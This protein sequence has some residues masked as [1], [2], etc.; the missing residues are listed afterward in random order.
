MIPTYYRTTASGEPLASAYLHHRASTRGIPLAGTFEL[1]ARCNFNCKMCYVHH[2]A[3]VDRELSTQSWIDLGKTAAQNGMLFLLL[4]GGEPLLREDFPEIYVA[5]KKLGLMISINTN[6]SLISDDILALFAEYPPSRVNISL[7]GGSDRT[8]R[9][10]CG[11]PAYGSVTENIQKLRALN[12]GVKLNCSV[13]P[14]NAADIQ[15]I[16]AFGQGL[17]IPVQATTYMFPPVRINGK[18]Y[19]DAPARFDPQ[20]AA[21]YQLVCREQYMSAAQLTAIANGIQQWDEDCGRGEFGPMRCRAGRT[22]FWVTW[23][24]RMLPCGMFPTEGHSI[25]AMG[26]ESAWQAVLQDT[27]AIALPR[28]CS[29]CSKQDRC[30]ACAASCLAENGDTRINPQYICDMMQKLDD[31]TKEKYGKESLV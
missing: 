9:A 26:F 23:D 17:N 19:G 28:E 30:S 6:G 20:Q 31:L 11:N 29:G 24:G 14:E 22:S 10:L 13:T 12:I 16:F 15:D 3:Q 8:Y 18:Q 4:T 25:P 21:H 2:N 27:Q 5:L 1:T 7:Y